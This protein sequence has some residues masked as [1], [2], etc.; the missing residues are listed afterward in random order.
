MTRVGLGEDR[1]DFG[2][3]AKA[4]SGKVSLPIADLEGI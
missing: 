4:Y 2:I 3:L 1:G